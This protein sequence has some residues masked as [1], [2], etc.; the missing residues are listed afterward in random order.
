MSGVVSALL[1]CCEYSPCDCPVTSFVVE[2][3][4][5]MQFYN[6]CGSTE[7]GGLSQYAG[8]MTIGTQVFVFT[9]NAECIYVT[10][11]KVIVTDVDFFG[12]F[13][14]EA[15][16]TNVI[17]SKVVIKASLGKVVG[18]AFST[19]SITVEKYKIVDGVESPDNG[20]GEPANM[21][22]SPLSFTI[23]CDSASSCPCEG[24]YGD[25][26]DVDEYIDTCEGTLPARVL[27]IPQGVTVS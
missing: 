3:P 2:W 12:E 7:C 25:I 10:P 22:F 19:V 9:Q 27:M 1:C 16:P 18:Q 21:H 5:S 26:D 6:E 13:D 24:E 14:C 23:A 8:S 11:D 20:F 4:C 17:Q 15:E